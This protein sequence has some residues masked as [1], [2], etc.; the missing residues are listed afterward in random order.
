MAL[1]KAEFSDD[2]NTSVGT[3]DGA[4][5][6]ANHVLCRVGCPGLLKICLAH[7]RKF[8]KR[9]PEG[10]FQLLICHR[11]TLHRSSQPSTSHFW[12]NSWIALA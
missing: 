3:I 9:H 1:G 11:L 4:N 12:G 7:P 2:R 10:H 5:E 8:R 6:A